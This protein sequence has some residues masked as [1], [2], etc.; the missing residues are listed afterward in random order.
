MFLPLFAASQGSVI[1]QIRLKK[2]SSSS[3][4]SCY[5]GTA[6]LIK[7]S[8]RRKLTLL[9]QL[10]KDVVPLV[11]ALC[12]LGRSL[13]GGR[14]ELF[15]KEDNKDNMTV[16]HI[17]CVLKAGCASPGLT[18]GHS[19]LRSLLKSCILLISA[20]SLFLIV[21]SRVSRLAEPFIRVS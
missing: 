18:N 20:S 7:D 19:P 3:F 15:C 5:E 12:L 17:G 4:L 8:T 10:H 11:G 2:M 1:C 16:T 14:V 6:S 21:F 13:F 9:Q